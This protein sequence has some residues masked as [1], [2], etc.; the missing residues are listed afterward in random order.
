MTVDSRLQ[1]DLWARAKAARWG[2]SRDRFAVALV[3]SAERAFAGQTPAPAAVERFLRGLHLEDLALACACEDGIDEAWEHFIREFRPQLYRAATAID[4]GGARELADGLYADLF[5]LRERDG[6]RQSLFRYFHGRSSL[7]TW[8]RAVMAQRHVDGVR[9]RRREQPLPED[10]AESMVSTP[11]AAPDVPRLVRLL[12]AA[13]A[14]VLTT[15]AP[16]DRLRL[17]CYHAQNLT[18]AQ[19]GRLTGEHEATVSRHL[20]RSRQLVRHEVERRLREE[21]GMDD[22]GI[23]ECLQAALADTGTFDLTRVLDEDA[24]RKLAAADRS[25]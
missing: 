4:A 14:A 8:L 17:A 6:A 20:T 16:R 21:H 23:A 25:T 24:A 18:L 9:T 19:I 10:D 13:L 1:D 22:S 2:L 15:L 7:A 12:L 11:V 3:R 5:G